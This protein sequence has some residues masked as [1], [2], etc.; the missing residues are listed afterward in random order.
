MS[1]Y[2][3]LRE[4]FESLAGE[5]ESATS[6]ATHL[7]HDLVWGPDNEPWSDSEFRSFVE[8]HTGLDG[9]AWE[10]WRLWPRR[11]G[12]SR[13]WGCAYLDRPYVRRF[14]QL[15]TRAFRVLKELVR[16]GDVSA[17]FRAERFFP[18]RQS[19]EGFH[20][21][22]LEQIH[23]WAYRFPTERLQGHC[24]WWNLANISADPDDI[25]QRMSD[26]ADGSKPFHLHPICN[27]MDVDV[28]TASAAFIHLCLYPEETIDLG[29]RDGT[30]EFYFPAEPSKPSWC[31]EEGEHGQLWF[32]DWL[33]KAFEKEAESQAIVLDAFEEAGWPQEIQN[34]FTGRRDIESYEEADCLRHTVDSL[35][36]S[37]A[38]E[39]AIK[40][41]TKENRTL[42]T[43]TP[44]VDMESVAI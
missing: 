40:F 1:R 29:L 4:E 18:L 35:N 27:V 13:Y 28:F 15:A 23:E 2:S 3:V 32:D 20:C 39:G 7:C 25:A 9:V 8:A 44:L 22:W 6:P 42:V 34:P 14:E 19:P 17:D 11:D 31:P 5:F 10:E 41:G 36:R 43:W 30:P 33:I 12:S 24:R 21:D 26:A 16:I 38:V 37:H